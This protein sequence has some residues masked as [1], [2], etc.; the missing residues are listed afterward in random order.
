MLVKRE[1]K[2]EWMS[3]KGRWLVGLE[4]VGPVVGRKKAVVWALG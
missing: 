1:A 3:M 2:C 4:D